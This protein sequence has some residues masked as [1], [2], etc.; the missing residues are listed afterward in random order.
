VQVWAIAGASLIDAATLVRVYRGGT[1]ANDHVVA[2][3]VVGCIAVYPA[4]WIGAV[5]AGAAHPALGTALALGALLIYALFH[6]MDGRRDPG[7]AIWLG[8]LSQPAYAFSLW[9]WALLLAWV[10]FALVTGRPPLWPGAWLLLPAGLTAW[11][12]SWTYLRGWDVH[13][14]AV[15]APMLPAGTKVRVVHLSDIHVSPC[16]RRADMERLVRIVNRAEPDVVV[17]SGDLVMP[18]S[19]DEHGFL[20]DALRRVNAPV[21]AC[22]GNHDVPIRD[23]LRRELYEIGAAMLVDEARA[24]DTKGVRLEIAGVDFHWRDARRHVEEA[25]ASLAPGGA[26]ARILLAHDP[27]L[28]AWVPEGRF[29]LVL[30]GHTHGGQAGLDM[31]GIG[32]S[33][34]RLLGVHD[35]GWWRRGSMLQYVHRG[36]WH[37][38]LPPRMGIA[39]EIV[40]HRLEAGAPVP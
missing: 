19:E 9:A 31:F 28:F 18:F 1:T 13:E 25:L 7:P 33:P 14:R 4:L 10:P 16:M 32:W 36:N 22:P 20:I 11:G 24:V 2:A 34:L 39:G 3:F 17:I 23:R 12:T 15:P 29:D 35:Q 6:L 40:V 27:R 26:S 37:T 5:G 21:F 38:G 30:S 8:Y